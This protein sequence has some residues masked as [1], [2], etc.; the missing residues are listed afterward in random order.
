MLDQTDSGCLN[1]M[2]VDRPG[3]QLDLPGLKHDAACKSRGRIVFDD[4]CQLDRWLASSV[5][6]GQHSFTQHII[7]AR[8][9]QAR[10]MV[11]DLVTP[12]LWR[13]T[14]QCCEQR[15]G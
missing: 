13:K 4:R 12:S 7:I 15:P 9:S 2:G 11:L 5:Q 6:D 14:C 8:R 3:E 1:W 10:K